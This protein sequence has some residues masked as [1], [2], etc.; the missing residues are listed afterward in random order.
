MNRR[1]IGRWKTSLPA[2]LY[3]KEL[4]LLKFSIVTWVE[5]EIE[6]SVQSLTKEEEGKKQNDTCIFFCVLELSDSYLMLFS[7]SFFLAGFPQ[8]GFMVSSGESRQ[9]QYVSNS[10]KVVFDLPGTFL[11]E[12]EETPFLTN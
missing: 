7:L 4:T 9:M 12:T 6:Y 3:G 8:N 2:S 1:L 5:I 10:K 11:S